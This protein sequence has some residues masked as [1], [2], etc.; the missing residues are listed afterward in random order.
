MS[1]LVDGSTPVVIQGITGRQ[2]RLHT[3][4]SLGY[5]TNIVSGVTP[6]R[7]GEEVCGVPVFDTVLE[8]VEKTGATAS[9]IYVPAAAVPSAVEE[10]VAAGIK[11]IVGTSEGI[12]RQQAAYFRALT[13]A[14]GARFIG[15]NTTGILSAGKAKLG[16]IGGED[17]DYIYPPGRIG[18]CSRS[19]GITA[20]IA[21]SLKRGGYG[22]S[23]A[24][25][26]G[27]DWITG[28]PM[29]EYVELFMAD[30][31]TDAI[32]LFGEPGTNNEL[33]VAA[34]LAENGVRKPVVALL[35]GAFQENYPQGISFG[36]AAAMIC[37]DNQTI[38]AKRR[39]LKGAGAAIVTTLED[40]PG[41]LGELGVK[42]SGAG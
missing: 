26:M 13:R 10:A 35:A 5:G 12:S 28:M 21:L 40:I 30:G 29:E 36:H 17:S 19:G 2:G 22:I 42:P 14:H 25:A 11:L 41:A 39:A 31:E 8:A 37:N 15:F 34:Y 33:E 9:V 4:Y 24:V 3:E 23:T 7:G 18:V 16:G 27:G 20:E 6:G 1:I 32:V 38:S